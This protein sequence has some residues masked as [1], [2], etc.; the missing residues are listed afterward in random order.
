M[1]EA[2]KST[3][4]KTALNAIIKGLSFILKTSGLQ[5]FSLSAPLQ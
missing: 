3:E 4:A 5:K 1:E 2:T